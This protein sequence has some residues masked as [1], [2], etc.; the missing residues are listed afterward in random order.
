MCRATGPLWVESYDSELYR[1]A[2]TLGLRKG[3]PPVQKPV[4]AHR[5]RQP[6][7]TKFAALSDESGIRSRKIVVFPS[8]TQRAE[9]VE[10]ADTDFRSTALVTASNDITVDKADMKLAEEAASDGGKSDPDD[11]GGIGQ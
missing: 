11:R 4:R 5:V 2:P 10:Q 6:T 1:A 7:K 9:M 8:S 3:D